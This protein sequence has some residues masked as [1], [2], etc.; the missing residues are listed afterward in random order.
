MK[1]WIV[2]IGIF[3]GYSNL[4]SQSLN[5]IDLPFR[6]ATNDLLSLALAG[7]L[8]NPQFSDI[9]LNDDN[10]KDL[11][12]FDRSANVSLTF[13]NNGALGLNA[14]EFAPDYAS[15]FPPFTHWVL[16]RDYNCDGLD[17]IFGYS[18]EPGIPGIEV[19]RAFYN[20]S[21]EVEFTKVLF[22]EYFFDI[23]WFPTQSNFPSNLFVRNIDIPDFIDVDEDGDL[24]V[25][26]FDN[27]GAYM[28]YYEN[29]SADMG[30]GC[31]SLIFRL[32]DNCWGRFAESSVDG[33]ILLSP[34][35]DSCINRSTFIGGLSP[36]QHV[37]STLLAFDNDNDLDKEIL[38]G[39]AS[40]NRI[41]FL[42]NGLHEDTAFMTVV[43]PLYPSFD[44]PVDLFTFPASFMLDVNNDGANDLLIAPNDELVSE[45][46]KC[47][48]LYL[49]EGTN[50][51][52]GFV[53]EKNDFLVSEMI[54][55]G[56]S[57]SPVF[58]DHNGDGLLDIVVGSQGMLTPPGQLASPTSIF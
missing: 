22:P 49:N 17:D 35:S 58:F 39:D 42:E 29:K 46:I 48:W 14:W 20:A 13:L 53:F 15:N 40:L 6:N 7:G 16:L 56:T 50:E 19:H 38:I 55:V 23:L 9:D 4:Q 31:D 36:L 51:V 41:A 27:G 1:I 3:F 45:N 30:Y 11:Y 2:L 54:D 44:V 26:T 8:N 18:Q 34:S 24:D 37:G 57:S 52:P 33:T 21:N 25:L 10:L 12:I 47:S 28:E 32:V 5:R 43:D